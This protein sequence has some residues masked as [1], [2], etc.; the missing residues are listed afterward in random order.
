MDLNSFLSNIQ[1]ITA[2]D[3]EPEVY[4]EGAAIYVDFYSTI[5]E[6][7]VYSD[8]HPSIDVYIDGEWIVW[9]DLDSNLEEQQRFRYVVTV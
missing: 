2:M 3:P 4:A 1:W 7:E 8:R 5:S 9:D 6:V